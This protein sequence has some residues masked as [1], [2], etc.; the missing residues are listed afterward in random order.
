MAALTMIA[1]AC[2]RRVVTASG[3]SIGGPPARSTRSASDQ[4]LRVGLGAS[5][6]SRLSAN[7]DWLLYAS[8]GDRLVARVSSGEVWHVE[9]VGERLRGVGPDGIASVWQSGAVSSDSA[10]RRSRICCRALIA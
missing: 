5:G 3:G 7:G 10:R 2:A 6:A 4:T 9:R 1:A 8:D